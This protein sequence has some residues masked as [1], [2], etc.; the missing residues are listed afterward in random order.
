MTEQTPIATITAGFVDTILIAFGKPIEEFWA[1]ARSMDKEKFV[2]FVNSLLKD[3]Q[4][5]RSTRTVA[6]GTKKPPTKGA[7]VKDDKWFDNGTGNA[8][9]IDDWANVTTATTKKNEPTTTTNRTTK[10]T[11][12]VFEELNF[13][14][15]DEKE[16]VVIVNKAEPKADSD[17]N[18]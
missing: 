16:K 4:T 17:F 18:W 3:G 7:N 5:K 1:L 13:A 11:D 6:G 9:S 12:T 8:A 15:T 10:K 14:T 2:Q